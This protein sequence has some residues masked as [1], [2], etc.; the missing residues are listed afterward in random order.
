VAVAE[1]VCARLRG[2]LS[3]RGQDVYL[4]ASIGVAVADEGSDG[5]GLLR[6]ADLAMYRAKE[7]A[8]GGFALYDPG[9]HE[10]LVKRV[11]LEGELREALDRDELVL[12]YQ[13]TWDLQ[14]GRLV[15]FE[16]LVR[17]Q[18]PERGLLQPG[19]FIPIAEETGLVHDIGRFV[20]REACRQGAIWVAHHPEL[21][22]MSLA[23]NLSAPNLRDP[24]LSGWVAECLVETGLPPECL[25]LE[26]TESMLIE[27]S[28]QMI[29]QLQRLK[30][31]GVRLAIDDFGTGFSSLSYLHRFPVDILK[32]D[33]SFIERVV[34]G[35]DSEFVRTIVQ[36][37]RSLSLTT[38]AEGI[39][40]Q[41]QL[42]ALRQT[43]C[44]QGQ[45]FHFSEA[46][47]SAV[48]E[49]HLPAWVNGVAIAASAG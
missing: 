43:G 19:M 25:V 20:L 22:R 26:M 9:M 15:G 35:S 31:L 7:A 11:R 16:A 12:H 4:R 28:I 6:S 23:V 18:H 41:D 37:G 45:G 44:E 38:I 1:R 40:G 29:E 27:H 49:E 46:V 32:I 8:D 3:V 39:E 47:P 30:A 10:Q 33:R 34:S 17:W 2:K 21:A 24:S 36:L 13:P 42:T 5:D 48:V 14:S